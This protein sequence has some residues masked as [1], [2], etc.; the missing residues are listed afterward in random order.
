MLRTDHGE[1][2]LSASASDSAALSRV[3]G[4]SVLVRGRARENTFYV[5][6]FTVTSVDGAPVADGVLARDGGYLAL[7]MRNG[8]IALGNPPAALDPLVGAR[9]WISGPLDT[10]PNGYGVIVPP[11]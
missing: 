3:G 4:T 9:V 11:R 10:G 7:Q 1:L 8:Q 5:V 2:A 6:S